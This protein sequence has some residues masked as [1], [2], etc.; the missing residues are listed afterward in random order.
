MLRR[1]AAAFLAVLGIPGNCAA[2]Q[3]HARDF[4]GSTIVSIRFQPPEQP[5]EPEEL[6]GML[7][8]KPGTAFRTRDL[9]AAI[10][11]LFRTGRYSDISVEGRA[12]NGG[13]EVIIHTAVQWFV[14]RLEVSGDLKSPP[15]RGQLYA[16]TDLE[17]GR[18]LTPDEISH[19]AE[20]IAGLL[21]RNGFCGAKVTPA[22]AHSS[23]QQAN[24]DFYVEPG[25][26]ADLRPP[27]IAADPV[28]DPQK[29]AEAADLHGLFGWRAATE[30]N[31]NRGLRRVRQH[32]Q[33]SG[34][35]LARVSLEDLDCNAA[36]N[37]VTP[38]FNV[39]GGPKVG[40]ETLGAEISQ[41]RLKKHVPIFAVGAVDRDLLAEGASNLRDYLQNQGYF[42]AQV[43]YEFRRTGLDRED[44]VY[45]IDLGERQKLVRV[46]VE[47]N[48]YFSTETIRER[49]FVE[50]AGRIRL[51]HGRFSSS[52]ARR[53]RETIEA[54]YRASGFREAA[55]SI[56]TVPNYR[57][58][59]GHL[60]VVVRITEGPQYLVSGVS[61]NG[62]RQ[63]DLA[64]ITASLSSVPGQ[65]FSE[66]NV[67]IDRDYI[68]GL[69]NASGFPN[70]S[71]NWS[72]RPGAAPHTVSIEYTIT[73]GP[74]LFVRDVLVTGSRRTRQSLIGLNLKV[75]KGDPLSL[76][77]MSATQENLYNLGIFERV[78]MA[79]QNPNGETERKYLL[80]DL[81]EADRYRVALGGGAEIARIG[82]GSTT[83]LSDPEGQAGFSPRVTIDIT[84]QNLW[85]LAHRGIFVGRASTLEQLGSLSYFWPRFLGVPAREITFTALADRAI[86]VNTFTSR[87]LEGFAQ[88]SQKLTRSST[89]LGTLSLRRVSVSNVKIDPA[90]IP[91]LSSPTRVGMV[92]GA[93]I[94]DRRDNPIDAVRGMF[95]TL[96]AGVAPTFLGSQVTFSRLFASNST[97]HPF[98]KNLVFARRIQ[99]GWLAP[100]RVEPGIPSD[101]AIPLPERFYAGGAA[102][103]RGFPENQAGPRDL[104]TGFPIGGNAVLIHNT[105]LRFP[106]L[107]NNIRGVLFHDMGNVYSTVRDISFRF[108]QRN[109]QDFN[110]MVHAVGFGIRYRTPVGPFRADFAYNINPPAFIGL[111]G[112]TQELLAG[113]AETVRKRI[114]RF[115]FFISIG[116]AF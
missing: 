86:N 88:M 23:H 113:T 79:I 68:I 65:P 73:E 52:F 47:G 78:S 56:D 115:Q 112:T 30:N 74:R 61:I 71:F 77:A 72:M 116:Q 114:S 10:R 13:V 49:M 54:L 102:S 20:Q 24:I 4:E 44:I 17:L 66:T 96:D 64:E 94:F 2:Q 5:L 37:Q 60:A 103:H 109:D 101:Q 41:R 76:S 51:R 85:G 16:A 107:G 104:V 39:V 43:D 18:P 14:G 3:V 31:I 90:L 9:R 110:Y 67:G 48:R 28:I 59:R 95:N 26:R 12:V 89:V 50:P 36:S 75:Q 32:Y 19:A 100:F 7:P 40:I 63:L 6:A 93:Y 33:K 106:L 29:V 46:M 22:V 21:R 92:S 8:L 42:D 11:R 38:T 34:R 105:E 70:A 87:R 98:R 82:G 45:K 53:D 57:G 81:E 58:K 62:V 83:T 97:F 80:Y 35:L 69:Y 84:R 91:L 25:P 1:G 108:H 55:V 15:T 27:V 99:F 111:E